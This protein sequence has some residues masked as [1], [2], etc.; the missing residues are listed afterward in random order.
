MPLMTRMVKFIFYFSGTFKRELPS[1]QKQMDVMLYKNQALFNLLNL[2]MYG[3]TL[4]RSHPVQNPYM[5]KE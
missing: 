3:L 1:V 4:N 2:Q 5:L